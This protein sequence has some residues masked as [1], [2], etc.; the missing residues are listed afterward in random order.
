M[1]NS[2]RQ[3]VSQERIRLRWERI[4]ESIGNTLFRLGGS[5]TLVGGSAYFARSENQLA[6]FSCKTGRWTTLEGNTLE[7]G[8]WHVAQ[9]SEDKIYFFGGLDTKAV[10]EYDIPLRSIQKVEARDAGP[11]DRI[12]MSSVFAAWRNEIITFGGST[13]STAVHSNETYAFNVKTFSWKR[14][15]FRGKLPIARNSH[16]ATICGSKMYIYGGFG[17]ENNRYLGDLWVAELGRHCAPFWSLA[18]VGGGIPTFRSQ[19]TLNDLN[20]FLVLFGGV[21]LEMNTRQDLRIY[22]P[23]AGLWRGQDSRGISVDGEAPSDTKFHQALSMNNGILYFTYVGVFM[24]K[25]E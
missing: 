5:I 4:D 19:A 14:I 9:L 3:N 18:R 15:E 2:L 23:N 24:L 13:Y 1:N 8:D 17:G 21:S 12:L 10:V 20:G 25:L 22:S 11:V 16:G 7:I 6:T